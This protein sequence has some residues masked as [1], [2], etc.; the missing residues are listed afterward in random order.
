MRRVF[1]SVFLLTVFLVAGLAVFVS[2]QKG[3]ALVGLS[4]GSSADYYHTLIGVIT[5]NWREYGQL[6]TILQGHLPPQK[7]FFIL[8]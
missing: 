5:G 1:A 2:A 7:Y 3:Q 4:A 6:F 8:T